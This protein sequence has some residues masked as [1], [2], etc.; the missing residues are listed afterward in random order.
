MGWLAHEDNMH[1]TQKPARRVGAGLLRCEGSSQDGEAASDEPEN[2]GALLVRLHLLQRQVGC[3]G[4]LQPLL[5]LQEGAFV[6]SDRPSG[7]A[8]SQRIRYHA[9][10]V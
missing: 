2:Q 8:S 5:C 7:G 3:L 4:C 1:D 6:L 9:A 10:R